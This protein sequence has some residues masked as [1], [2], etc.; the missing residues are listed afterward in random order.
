[1][2]LSLSS[3]GLGGTFFFNNLFILLVQELSNTSSQ[4]SSRR[5]TTLVYGHLLTIPVE[6]LNGI[7][8]FPSQGLGLAHPYEFWKHEFKIEVEYN[9]FSTES[10]GGS[11]VPIPVSWLPPRLRIFHY[12]LTH[13]FLP[14]SFNQDCVLPMN[15]WIIASATARRK[16]DFASIMFGQFLPV[17]NGSY[18]GLLPFGSI[19]TRLLIN[20]GVDL[21]EFRSIFSTMYVSALY[22][23]MVLDLPTDIPPPPPPPSASLL[24]PPSKIS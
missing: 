1:M 8:G 10:T 12:F 4:I 24:G 2:T 14:R 18:K 23:L 5:F 19:I 9:N 11:D 17:G 22:V 15:L 7:L 3:K 16:L 13:V 20:L 6:A 21:S